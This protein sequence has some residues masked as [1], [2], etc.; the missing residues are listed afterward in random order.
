MDSLIN[1]AGRALAV[2]DPLAA[3]NFVALREDPPALALRGIAM[4]QLGDMTRAKALLQRAVKAFGVNEPLSRARCVVAEAEV[5]LAARDLRWPV[6]ALEAARRVLQD[7]GDG[8]NAAHARCLQ[9]RRLLLIGQL[10][11]AEK[12]LGE[13]DPAPLPPALHAVHELMNAGI[14]L[15]RVQAH[16]AQTALE[17][18]Q[19]AAQ[20]AAIPALSAEI[21]HARQVLEAP[22]AR[23]IVA[24]QV[25]AVTLAQV[26]ALFASPALVVD[27][28]RY[29]VCGTGMTV[30]LATRPVLFNL[31]RLLA[32][33]WPGD[34]PRAT[35]VAKAFRLKLDDESHRA[36]LRVEI[37]RLRAALQPLAGI[38]ATSRGYALI[39]QDVA[40]LTLPLEDK[41]AALLALLADGEAWSSSALAL[42]LGSSQ[43]QVQRGLETLAA[44][45][46]VQSF[47]VGR[48]RRWLTP[49]VPG[50]ATILLLPVSL[51]NG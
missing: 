35:L 8:V 1:A 25:Q 42:A 39:A 9:I 37:G 38:A 45:D 10:E 4:A 14:A 34:V 16:K 33:A 49:P 5:A 30:A 27:A 40:L 36:R 43:R 28:C 22:A 3:L 41:Y 51:G 29:N 23:L 21:G 31:V 44:Q 12:L 47:G 11:A 17:R 7:H 26:E 15:R 19:R 24:G 50:F 13:L 32:E 20:S 46:K 6:E 18:A 48:A 2:G